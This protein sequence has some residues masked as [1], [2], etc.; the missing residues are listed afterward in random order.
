MM[1]S[2]NKVILLGNLTRDPELR[3][4]EGKKSVC[5][6]GLATNRS[7]TTE[8]GKQREEPEYHRLVAWDKLAEVCNTYLR[9]GRKVY[10]EG[11]LHTR[12][13]TAKDGT[14]KAATEIVVAELVLLDPMPD[15]LREA[16][17]FQKPE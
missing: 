5:A 10:V 15:T 14:E 1:K 13:F 2:V 6:F 12:S 17:E 16:V 3:H 9:K 7:W 11:R 8:T 4:T